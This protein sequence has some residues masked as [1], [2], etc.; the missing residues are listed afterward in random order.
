MST[1]C[2]GTLDCISKNHCKLLDKDKIDQSNHDFRD[3][4][5]EEYEDEHD[6]AEMRKNSVIF[7]VFIFMQ[8]FN[9]IN[10]RKIRNEYNIFQGVFDSSIFCAIFVGITGLQVRSILMAN[11]HV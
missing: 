1:W 7:N 5:E 2:S 6:D 4:I 9:E 8:I 10:A 3:H 11:W